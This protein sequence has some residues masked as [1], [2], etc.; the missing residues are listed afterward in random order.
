MAPS[1]S[2]NNVALDTFKNRV[3]NP[4][5][6]GYRDLLFKVVIGGH[7][8][9]VRRTK[10]LTCACT[11]SAY[12]HAE[13]KL[14]RPC[15]PQWTRAVRVWEGWGLGEGVSGW[16]VWRVARGKVVRAGVGL[17]ESDRCL[18]PY[19]RSHEA[20]ARVPHLLRW[21]LYLFTTNLLIYYLLAQVQ[22]HLAVIAAVKEKESA[23]K[24]YKASEYVRS[25]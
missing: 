4:T 8:C 16:R 23:N 15:S 13:A 21:V 14:L 1:L 20:C 18:Q 2:R 17:T 25:K 3:A 10:Y 7:V 6:E 22:L 9:E 11:C 24:L 19:L 5:N 12:A